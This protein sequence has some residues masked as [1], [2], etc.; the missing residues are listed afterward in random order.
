MTLSSM[1]PVLEEKHLGKLLALSLADTL[2]EH[3][4]ATRGATV[5]SGGG[6]TAVA[7]RGG[8]AAVVVAQGG[9]AVATLL[10]V[11]A[12]VHGRRGREVDAL[13]GV[14]GRVA[15][16]AVGGERDRGAG[17][18]VVR[19][20]RAARERGGALGR[21]ALELG[22]VGHGG[23]GLHLGLDGGEVEASLED[24]EAGLDDR[25]QALLLRLLGAED[26]HE[27]VAVALTRAAERV[28]D[29]LERR[30]GS[31]LGGVL[32]TIKK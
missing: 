3:L 6:R 8:R 2:E 18:R 4:E 10:G 23:H 19:R 21:V 12:L 22:R 9:E 26:G 30:G 28:E 17:R 29:R 5:V 7:R 31:G 15:R 20:D 32:E 13:R 1:N 27:E 24:G 25:R 11:V 14:A 16:V